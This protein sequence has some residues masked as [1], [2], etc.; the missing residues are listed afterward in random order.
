MGGWGGGVAERRRQIFISKKTSA[1]CFSYTLV[2]ILLLEVDL[3]VHEE[4]GRRGGS[5]HSEIVMSSIESARSQA[6]QTV[7]ATFKLCPEIVLSCNS[8]S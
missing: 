5:G 3:S 6:M 4:V 8:V 7:A 2:T 1:Y